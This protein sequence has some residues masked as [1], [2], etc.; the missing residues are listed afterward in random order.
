M[1]KTII[2]LLAAVILLFGA[3]AAF[4]QY[5]DGE[6]TAKDRAD[7]QGYV[8][9]IKLVVEGGKIV[10]IEYDEFKGKDSKKASNYVN[11]EMKKRGG[12]SYIDALKKIEADLLKTQDP[13]KVDKVSGATGLTK[14]VSDLAKKALV[15]K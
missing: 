3:A 14:R 1:N 7:R 10:K 4:A 11:S 8:G 5:K 13:D 15:K 2:V 9:D 12:I 6:F